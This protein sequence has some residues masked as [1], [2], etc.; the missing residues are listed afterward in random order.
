MQD[1][2]S[3]P[4]DGDQKHNVCPCASKCCSYQPC[5]VISGIS[6]NLSVLG[7]ARQ[8]PH[9]AACAQAMPAGRN[10]GS[11]VLLRNQVTLTGTPLLTHSVLEFPVYSVLKEGW[12][13]YY[14]S[15]YSLFH[16]NTASECIARRG[17]PRKGDMFA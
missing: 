5:L 16:S 8:L 14:C 2:I 11:C 4:L 7:L 17:H 12:S 1:L 10:L 15:E 13:Q 9:P 3:V 6:V